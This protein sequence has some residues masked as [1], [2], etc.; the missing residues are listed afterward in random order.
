MIL[1]DFFIN[2]MLSF[3]LIYCKKK[4]LSKLRQGIYEV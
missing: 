3:Y 2:K 1:I 4:K